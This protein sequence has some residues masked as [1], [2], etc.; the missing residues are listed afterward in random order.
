[1]SSEEEQRTIALAFFLSK[2][3]IDPNWDKILILTTHYQV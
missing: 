2:L 1:M 3:D